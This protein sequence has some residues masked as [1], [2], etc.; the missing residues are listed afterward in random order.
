[1]QTGPSQNTPNTVP[2]IAIHLNGSVQMSDPE[3]P[4][5]LENVSNL[6]PL[7]PRR[8][9]LPAS[10]VKRAKNEFWTR[11]AAARFLIALI[12]I[13]GMLAAFGAVM[14]FIMYGKKNSPAW[15][16]E[17]LSAAGFIAAPFILIR[18]FWKWPKR[19]FALE[20]VFYLCWTA[21][22]IATVI[23][24]V[25]AGPHVYHAADHTKK[26]F[27]TETFLKIVS[28]A[29]VY[30]WLETVLRKTFDDSLP[31]SSRNAISRQLSGRL[32]LYSPLRLSQTRTKVVQCPLR[33]RQAEV[34]V[35]ECYLTPDRGELDESPFSNL[36]FP[37]FNP[38]YKNYA[39]T[40]IFASSISL[41]ATF[42]K[43][44]VN[45]HWVVWKA[46]LSST[47][48][49]QMFQ[50]M[51]KF[52]WI[53]FQTQQIAL[54]FTL[55]VPDS[56]DHLVMVVTYILERLP[57]GRFFATSP[58]FTFN[59]LDAIALGDENADRDA[60]E[61]G[62]GVTTQSG[63]LMPIYLGLL[64]G[65]IYTIFAHAL[66]FRESPRAYLKQIFHYTEMG[67][68]IA[69]LVGVIFRWVSI[70]YDH[71]SVFKFNQTLYPTNE[72]LL[73]Y[74]FE[75]QQTSQYW[76]ESRRILAVA[77]FMHVFTFL[78][79]VTRISALDL[80]TST[81]QRSM[82][83]LGSFSLSFGVVFFAF[84]SLFYLVFSVEVFEYNSFSRS[85][86]TLWLAMLGEIEITPDL[87][88]NRL[89]SLPIIVLFTF[90]SVFVLLTVIIAIIS[91]AHEST[92]RQ[93]RQRKHQARIAIEQATREIGKSASHAVHQGGAMVSSVLQRSMSLQSVASKIRAA[94]PQ[95]FRETPSRTPSPTFSP[96]TG[97]TA[98]KSGSPVGTSQRVESPLKKMH[99]S[100]KVLIVSK[101]DDSIS[102]DECKL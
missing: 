86:A 35:T 8:K 74:F 45:G 71:C 44:R 68:M 67:W 7:P 47:T 82:Y 91:D 23:K 57:T 33:L 22:V 99:E 80:L 97:A 26:I 83:E 9:S 90:I 46:S 56:D 13:P 43:F 76:F 21:G 65:I 25:L 101:T 15:H 92:R 4:T 20:F 19:L 54:D 12:I 40:D 49:L 78:K 52:D 16:V 6:R 42:G 79:F 48:V 64:P 93:R 95:R 81:M 51:K 58:L 27:E 39:G 88:H 77:L 37:Y 66:A 69:V 50:A 30:N 72:T 75:F 55:L 62:K 28:E 41:D 32:F 36:S 102:V 3:R 98:A 34:A 18:W 29:D 63:Y 24:S 1:M 2:K 70:Y 11:K 17:M 5:T 60:N 85:I 87:W 96:H 31:S 53:D 61:C 10:Y 59:R 94:S 100:A 84:V 73:T 89:W 14:E 38:A